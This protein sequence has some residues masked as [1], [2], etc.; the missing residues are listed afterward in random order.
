MKKIYSVFFI[1][2][3]TFHLLPT[4]HLAVKR[5]FYCSLIPRAA[6]LVILLLAHLAGL[7]QSNLE[8]KL[9]IAC[10]ESATDSEKIIRL[11]QLSRFYYATK[12]FTRGDSAIERQ[13][14]L[15]EASQSQGLAIFA[16]FGN[17]GYRSTTASTRSRSGISLAYIN[18]ALGYARA[19]ELPDYIAMA[20]ANLSAAALT[21]GRTEEA[22]KHANYA[23]TS[24]LNSGN[25]SAKVVC[26]IQ[27]GNIYQQRSDVLMSFKTYTNAQNI[28]IEKERN[29][30][31]TQVYHAFA[32]LYK[33]LGNEDIAKKY[34]HRSLAI[35]RTK[36]NVAGRIYDNIFL[37]KMS[38]YNSGKEYLQEAVNLA[39]SINDVEGMIE[40]E[41]ILF[42]HMLFKETPAFLLNYLEENSDLKNVFENS[43]PGY[44]EWMKAEIY[45]YGGMPDSALHHFEKAEP[46]FGDAYDLNI[47]KNF[48][49]E[50]AYCY[51]L[52]EQPSRATGLYLRSFD[53]ARKTA[54][55]MSLKNY[56]AQLKSLY[57]GE[58][59]YKEAYAFSVLYEQY[60]DSVGMLG[61]EKDLALMEIDNVAKQTQRDTELANAEHRRKHNLQYMLITIVVAVVFLLM[62]MIGMFKVSATVIRIMGFLSLIFFFEFIILILDHWIHQL[63]HG[64]PWK[65]WLIK[66]G[67]ISMLLPLHHY[68]EHKLIRYLLSRHLIVVRNRLNPVSFFRNKK[69]PTKKIESPADSS[70]D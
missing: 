2:Y 41:R 54:D 31:L 38:N 20:Y 1:T 68:L 43:G 11:D 28:A 21:D 60:K 33:K 30:L 7:G 36:G 35:N 9:R 29:D 62:I 65:I 22:L 57:E 34:I 6:G 18:R 46:S 17:V 24:A 14:M 55:L 44:L 61:R 25:D 59:N 51:Q 27:L 45:L 64:E 12:N 16:L 13:I 48:Y 49:A 56:S 10:F 3:A 66:I 26:A 4:F 40:A 47:R 63:T 5:L 70:V 37:A 15:A 67:I 69:R 23:F 50:M 32:A 58:G 19:N 39:M 42:F 52:L 53:L 8:E